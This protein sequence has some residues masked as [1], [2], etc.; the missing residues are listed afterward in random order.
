MLA[1][2][3]L[4]T[5]H[6]YTVNYM[7]GW[8]SYSQV[9]VA[10]EASTQTSY[11]IKVMPVSFSTQAESE[12]DILTRLSHRS[13]IRLHEA[14]HDDLAY[15]LVTLHVSNGTLLQHMNHSH[16]FTEHDA[17]HIFAQVFDGVRYLH[18]VQQ[19]AHLDLK[20]ENIMIDSRSEV[21]IIDF[22]QARPFDVLA[23][24]AVGIRCGSRPYCAPEILSGRRL[25]P[26]VDIWSMGVILY[27]LVMGAL[28]FPATDNSRLSAQIMFEEVVFPRDVSPGFRSLIS[29][30]LE[31]ESTKRITLAEIAAHAWM[32]DSGASDRKPF[33]LPPLDFLSPDRPG[34]KLRPAALGHP[35]KLAEIEQG[36]RLMMSM[37]PLHRTRNLPVVKVPV[38]RRSD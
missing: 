3:Q 24:M 27:T 28:P 12:I 2:Y 26:S 6:N 1:N 33:A 25:T 11:A 23:R 34:A 35:S 37:R 17:R 20:L 7:I 29:K 18:D 19:I 9:Y 4:A 16:A 21:K 31:K 13:C 5:L 32:N 8:G 36:L 30:M 15:Y 10:E 22:G 38:R 14:L